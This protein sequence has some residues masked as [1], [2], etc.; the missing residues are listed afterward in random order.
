[1][2]GSISALLAIPAVGAAMVFW[3]LFWTGKGEAY[4]PLN[5]VAVA[6]ALFLMIAPALAIS[7]ASPPDLA[8]L[9]LLGWAAAAGMAIAGAGQLLLVARVIR[10]NMSFVTGGIGILP[11]LIWMVVLAYAGIVRGTPSTS[12]GW[13]A[14]LVLVLIVPAAVTARASKRVAL[15]WQSLLVAALMVWLAA[16]A[17]H[18][19]QLG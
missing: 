3:V 16:L 19:G 4:G 17:R 9:P 6:A 11:V 2:L 18:L 8:W 1:V 13:T 10:L 12:I 15:I 14:A 7:G 5:D